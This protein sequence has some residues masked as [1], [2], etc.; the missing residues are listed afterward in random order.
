MSLTIFY[1]SLSI[2]SAYIVP[3]HNRH[4]I[5]FEEEIYARITVRIKNDGTKKKELGTEDI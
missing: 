3:A 5:K 2:P 1:H 4:A